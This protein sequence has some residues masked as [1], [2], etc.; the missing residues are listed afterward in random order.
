MPRV[1]SNCGTQNTADAKFCKNCGSKLQAPQPSDLGITNLSAAPAFQDP[2]HARLAA[3][4][5]ARLSDKIRATPQ[6]AGER[7]IVTSLFADVVGST[8]LAEQMDPEDWTMVMNRAFDALVPA[9]YR[10]EGTIARLMGDALL[11]FFGAPL[12]HEDDPVRAVYAGLDLLEAAR[13]YA[14]EVRHRY[15]INFAIRV[16]LNTGPVVVGQVGSNLVYEYTAMGDAVNLAAR[17]QS[18]AQPMTLLITDNTYRFVAPLFEC[19]DA[20]E[21][22]IKGKRELVR[23]YQVIA[24]KAR[25]GRL[26]GVSGLESTMVGRRAELK[27]L[28]DLYATLSAG[29]GRGAVIIGEAG[30]GK[31]RLIAEWKLA[32]INSKIYPDHNLIWLEGHCLSYGQSMAYHLVSEL[33]RNFLGPSASA[34]ETEIRQTLQARCDDL[35]GEQEARRVFPYL[36][37]LLSLQLSG[38]ALERVRGLDP[39][40]LQTQYLVAISKLLRA[41]SDRKPLLLVL[42]DIHW[43]DPSSIDL[44]VKLLPISSESALLFCAVSRPDRTAP[45][46]K[47]ISAMRETMGAGLTEIHLHTLQ[48]KDVRQLVA[49]LLEVEALPDRVRKT[50]LDKAEGNPFFVEE[51]IRM[52]IDQGAIVRQEG[53]WAVTREIGSIDLPD[54]L[55]GLLLARIDRLP[56]DVKHTI[57][58]SSVIGRSFSIKVLEQ[59]LDDFPWTKQSESNT[60]PSPSL[61]NHLNMLESLGLLKIAQLQPDLQYKFHHAVA[62][63]VAYQSLV[64]R[65]R[66]VLHFAAGEALERLYPNRLAEFAATLGLHF[67]EGED[68]ERAL[69][70]LTL[71]G[72]HAAE[73]YANQ[74]SWMFYTRALRIIAKNP[75]SEV[76]RSQQLIHL[77]L[78]RGRALELMGRFESALENYQEME[79]QALQRNDKHMELSALVAR[80]VIY[81]IPSPV[82]DAAVG[83]TCS[84]QALALAKR[85]GDQTAEAKIHWALILQYSL[86]DDIGKAKKHGEQSL[87]LA[88]QL[89]LQ[90]QMAYTLSD[91]SNFVYM[92][93][94]DLES[95]LQAL[96]EAQSL[97]QELGNL[98]LLSNATVII[99][100]INFF[101]G[102]FDLALQKTDQGFGISQS[103]NNLWGQAHSQTIS[104]FVHL[105]LGDA[106]QAD[107]RLDQAFRLIDQSGFSALRPI[108][109]IV[110]ATLYCELGLARAAHQLALQAAEQSKDE[111]QFWQPAA[112]GVLASTLIRKGEVTSAERVI[113]RINKITR[114]RAVFLQVI[115]TA[116]PAMELQLGRGDYQSVIDEAEEFL[117]IIAQANART[118]MPYGF[119]YKGQALFALGQLEEAEQVLGEANQC[120]EELGSRRI[121]WRCLSSL[122]Q[123]TARRGDQAQAQFYREKARE[124]TDFIAEHAGSGELRNS[125]LSLP[126]VRW[127]YS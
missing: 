99:G 100:F 55:Q 2:R 94:G 124:I 76:N 8:A 67:E 116:I 92:P 102:R 17:M 20:G 114:E 28:M 30:L 85:L 90:E 96:Q 79:Q 19:Q 59:L 106:H 32:L 31:S 75:T 15:G 118:Y 63:E 46:W 88:R 82:F 6:L 13:N 24:P 81:S 66:Q 104:A 7:R 50:I 52:L 86:L 14:E 101:N 123:V 43:A 126:E 97:W 73:Q 62:H 103:I 25:P 125:F 36:A 16:G 21:L 117:K 4:A 113:K 38:E 80:T 68:D 89:N 77:Y 18:A 110:K 44:L 95:G 78:S 35:L 39:Q 74:E 34:D 40:A 48:E 10:Y 1:C 65:D 87:L 111:F 105:E 57:R 3:S 72:D 91:L 93:R 23:A 26:R 12:A 27:A 61:I 42:E 120:A 108:S 109:H 11:A 53:R 56:D 22:V 119:L 49:N 69:K 127:L 84:K 58:V 41:L 60:K 70:Y 51:V 29:L 54:T 112:L 107:T 121:W 45:G 122:A 115:F 33:L 37:H 83:E 5:P 47:L 64:K 71:A 9:I 98:P